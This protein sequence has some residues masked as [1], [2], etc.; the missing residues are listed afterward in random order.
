[1]I[2]LSSVKR[3]MSVVTDHSVGTMGITVLQK[4]G[5]TL[6]S[7][8]HP[9]AGRKNCHCH[10]PLSTDPVLQIPQLLQKLLG[11][12]TES[13]K[14][15]IQTVIQSTVLNKALPSLEHF[16]YNSEGEVLT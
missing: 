9:E 8:F 10:I 2:D 1:M 16:W 13:V 12:I 4:C 7:G 3:T 6:R 14:S 11:K 15:Q 5:H